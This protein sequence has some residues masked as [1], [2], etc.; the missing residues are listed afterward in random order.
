MKKF[1]N[2]GKALTKIEQKKIAGGGSC[3]WHTSDWSEQ[4]CGISK[5]E[6]QATQQ[7]HGG[8]WCCA[9]CPQMP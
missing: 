5:G 7:A 3:C 4:S 8:L 2:L 1:E 6:A 9:S